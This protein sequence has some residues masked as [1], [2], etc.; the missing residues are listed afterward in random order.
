MRTPWFAATRGRVDGRV[1]PNI[2]V[3]ITALVAAG[4]VATSCSPSGVMSLTPEVAVGETTSSVSA[5]TAAPARGMQRL[6]PSNPM[7]AAFPR[8][9]EPRSPGVM[10]ADE[11]ACRNEL[12]RIGVKYQDLAPIDDG[13]AC[14]VDYPVK[15]FSLSG[16]IAMTPAATLSCHMALA[17]AEWTKHELAPTAR[18]RYFTG[19]KAIHQGSSY[20]CRRIAGTSTPSE[21]SKG[22]ALDVMRI[23]LNSGRDIDVRRPGFFMFR[24]K[25][26]LNTVRQGGCEYFNTVLGPGYNADHADHFHFDIKERRNGYVACR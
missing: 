26:L 22:N 9:S 3:T 18:T 8:W 12:R 7:M 17:F 5:S 4:L 10:P 23:E 14:R 6:V 2:A 19:I 13:G 16:N 11:V 15:V 1:R 20:S 24:Q 21:H 25:N